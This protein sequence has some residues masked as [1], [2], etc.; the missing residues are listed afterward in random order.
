M[1]K[2]TCTRILGTA[3]TL[4]TVMI[5]S[6]PAPASA[7]EKWFVDA[8]EYP[9]EW[10]FFFST[11][12]LIGVATVIIVAIAWRIVFNRLPSPELSVLRPLE[13]VAPWIPRLLGVHLGIALLALGVRGAF[14]APALS[15]H[16]IPGGD[17]LAFAEGVLGV[18]FISGFRLRWAAIFLAISGP[19]ALLIEGPVSLLEAVP[20]LGIAGFLIVLSPSADGWGKTEVNPQTVR[21]AML[22]LRIGVGVGLIVLA[23]SEKFANPSMAQAILADNPDLNVFN[24]VGIS[25]SDETFTRIAGSTELLFG[26]LVLSGAGPQVMTLV[27]AVPFNL[28]LLLFGGTELI[29]HL[30]VYG[31]LL[32]FIVY[33]STSVTAKELRALRPAPKNA[34]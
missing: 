24:L 13:R 3:T 25:L 31:A 6:T 5:A 27:A 19:A 12:S 26:L 28:T 33:G 17:A 30:P 22:L 29:G 16:D 20:L 23:F 1:M 21:N 4:T 11:P 18:W 34:S 15:V 9:T 7:H 2:A 10:D 8:S 32:A 14:L